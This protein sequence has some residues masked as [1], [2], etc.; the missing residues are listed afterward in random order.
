MPMPNAIITQRIG[1]RFRDGIGGSASTWVMP[2]DG[3]S[4]RPH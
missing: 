2:V 4:D 1:E 3:S